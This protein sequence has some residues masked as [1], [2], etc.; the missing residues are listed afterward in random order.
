MY[1]L[2]RSMLLKA[3]PR[4]TNLP[5]GLA[6]VSMKSPCRERPVVAYCSREYLEEA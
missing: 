4:T 6:G 1:M 2:T 3:A 5:P